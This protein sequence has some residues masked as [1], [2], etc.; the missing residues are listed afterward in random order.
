MPNGPWG[1]MYHHNAPNVVD[2]HSWGALRSGSPLKREI[3]QQ[4]RPLA[5]TLAFLVELACRLLPGAGKN[6][7]TEPCAVM[8]PAHCSQGLDELSWNVGAPPP[9]TKGR[10]F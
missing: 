2:A 9:G 4:L 5:P 1:Q 3:Q 6:L 8:V 7:L 10:S